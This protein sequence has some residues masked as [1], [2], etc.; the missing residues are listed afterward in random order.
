[1]TAA[2]H[3]AIL[4]VCDRLT[5][6]AHF[7]PTTTTATAL[8]TARLL[9]DHVWCKHGISLDMVSDRDKLF[10]SNVFKHLCELWPMTQ[11]MSTSFH[12]QTDGQ[13]ERTNRKLEEI[14][15]NYI[16]PDMTNWDELLAPAEFAFNNARS[17][18]TGYTPFYLNYGRH[19]RVP[20]AVALLHRGDRFQGSVPS[21][22]NFVGHM[23][24][25]LKRAK[26]LIYAAQQR[27]KFYADHKYSVAEFAV[28]DKVLL[29]TKNL[30]LKDLGARKLLPK[31]IGPFPI[32]AKIGKV[33]YK[34][35][36]PERFRAHPVFHV[37]LLKRWK[38]AAMEAPPPWEHFIPSEASEQPADIEVITA[39]RDRTHGSLRHKEYFVRFAQ[40]AGHD[41]EWVPESRVSPAL[42]REYWLHRVPAASTEH[43][44]D[45]SAMGPPSTVPLRRSLRLLGVA[46]QENSPGA[47]SIAPAAHTGQEGPSRGQSLREVLGFLGLIIATS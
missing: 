29:S 5:K 31:Y 15:R 11:S 28:G 37:S 26:D 9:F 18:S 6:M 40:A 46:P 20:G 22:E 27:Q 36:L 43:S 8:E 24:T 1:V 19:P 44:A 45:G 12:P 32:L 13:T 21:V 35:K 2:G 30:S 38:P 4:V 14:L 17:S 47:S 42:V 7:I 25:L 10:T 34:L 39:H 16:D 41:A 23:D 3:A 33:A